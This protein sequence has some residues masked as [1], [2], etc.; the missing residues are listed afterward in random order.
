MS[1]KLLIEMKPGLLMIIGLVMTVI[2]FA[3]TFSRSTYFLP[4]TEPPIMRPLEGIEYLIVIHS[5][6]FLLIGIIGIFVI[7]VGFL[8]FW[9][10]KTGNRDMR[11]RT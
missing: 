1:N 8:M 6:A 10:E 7:I 3:A 2:G 9:K 11:K 5:Q 4:P